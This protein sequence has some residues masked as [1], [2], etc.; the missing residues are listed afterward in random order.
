[1]DVTTFENW[2]ISHLLPILKKQ[3]GRKILIGDNL[4]SHFS[5]NG[6]ILCQENDIDFVCLPPN[7]THLSQPLD[8]AYFRPLK[9]KLKDTLTKWKQ[10]ASGKKFNALP[11]DQ[12][13]SLLKRS[14]MTWHQ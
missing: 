13:S 9:M 3:A 2:F 6:L 1:M 7:S 8:I 14:W 4:S 11:K 10:L 12:F 5:S